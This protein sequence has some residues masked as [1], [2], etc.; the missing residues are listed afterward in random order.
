[1][2]CHKLY[3]VI[4]IK[5]PI[6]RLCNLISNPNLAIAFH[7]IGHYMIATACV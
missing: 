5:V 2:A 4:H 7:R 6:A 1:M 3:L